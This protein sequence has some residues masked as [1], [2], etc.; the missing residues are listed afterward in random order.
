VDLYL[1]PA[2]GWNARLKGLFKIDGITSTN[3]LAVGDECRYEPENQE[4]STGITP[5]ST[6]E[7]II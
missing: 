1:F 3:P 4:D 7:G 2:Y 6:T 5:P